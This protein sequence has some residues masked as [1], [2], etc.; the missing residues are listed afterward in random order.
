[1]SSLKNGSHGGAV[2]GGGVSVTQ[3]TPLKLI[4]HALEHAQKQRRPPRASAVTQL[5]VA[6]WLAE[7]YVVAPT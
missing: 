3:A 1:M 2:W 6:P 4:T 5:Q 7:F